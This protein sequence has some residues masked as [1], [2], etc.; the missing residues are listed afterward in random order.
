ME[1][2]QRPTGR[3]N[4]ALLVS[5]NAVSAFGNAIYL[6]AITLLLKR[7]TES[8]LMLG[9]LQ[10]L[11]LSP[12][13]LL[14]PFTGVVVDRVSR[15]RVVMLTDVY[16]GIVML[17]AGAA[18]AVP[19]L[20]STWLVLPVAFLAGVGHALFVPAM[21]ALIPAIVPTE[22]V[23]TA[24]GLRA[25]SSQIANLGGNAVGG[26]LYA[27]VGAPLLFALNGLTFLASAFQER[28]ITEEHGPGA[29]GSG[30]ANDH[31]RDAAQPRSISSDAREGFRLVGRDRALR[32]LIVS[33]AGLFLVSPLFMVALPFI[34]LDELGMAESALGYYFAL[35]LAGGIG[36]F[37]VLRRCARERML[38]FPLV[39]LAYVAMA[40]AFAAVAASTSATVLAG[41]ALVSGGAA[42]AVYLYAVTWIQSRTPA[43]A[44]GRVFALLEAASAFVAPI[45]YLLAG[46]V[47][48]TLGPEHR[49]IAF[50]S[51]ATAAFGWAIVVLVRFPRAKSEQSLARST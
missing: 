15:K 8:A 10:F 3:G 19:Q 38:G 35:A 40:F 41:V 51:V 34:L 26:A 12:G 7:L 18:L 20:A 4:L 11:A 37:A 46:G 27:L 25:L 23:Q 14:S 36:S 21:H 44:H 30:G 28:F 17:A 16:R 45:S 9:L 29:A 24:T 31:Q 6:I 47:I 42:A 43:R 32:L 2:A 5:G 13:F 49:W 39:G 33:Q 22:R 50:A 48:E 1:R